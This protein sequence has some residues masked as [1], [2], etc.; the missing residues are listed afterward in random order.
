MLQEQFLGNLEVERKEWLMWL[1]V[2]EEKIGAET[3]FAA[4]TDTLRNAADD[5]VESGIP[6]GS[7]RSSLRQIIDTIRPQSLDRA[8]LHARALKESNTTDT[9]IRIASVA[10]D[11]ELI[12]SLLE[13]G[14][15]FLENAEAAVANRQASLQKSGG[16]G[17][18][19]SEKRIEES[20]ESLKQSLGLLEQVAGVNR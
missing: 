16:E 8:F 9:L 2:T 15:L 13:K 18:M 11:R 10:E 19:E 5:L 4:L 12:D 14:E 17:L 6:C 3:S 20:L 1:S 7:S